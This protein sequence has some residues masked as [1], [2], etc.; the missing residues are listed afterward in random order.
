MTLVTGMR[1]FGSGGEL[2]VVDRV[3]GVLAVVVASLR[4]PHAIPPR[5]QLSRIAA[6]AR[7]APAA[8]S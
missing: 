2:V 8:Y 6:S 1:N 7:R 3:S 5:G 4:G